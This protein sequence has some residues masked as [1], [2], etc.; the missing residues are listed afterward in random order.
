MI[1]GKDLMTGDCSSFFISDFA[2]L[3]FSS[4][5]SSFFG[6][7]LFRRLSMEAWSVG[8][9]IFLKW[10]VPPQR[11]QTPNSLSPG[12][13][14]YYYIHINAGANKA[15]WIP[16]NQH[17]LKKIVV[18]DKIVVGEK[19]RR[20]WWKSS[21]FGSQPPMIFFGLMKLTYVWSHPQRN[22]WR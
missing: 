20:G 11:L 10:R 21:L 13:L 4:V 7:R 14:W 12:V 18:G 2:T 8:H 15:P 16:E 5:T 6:R 19:N 3:A 9:S 22:C 17:H 1:L